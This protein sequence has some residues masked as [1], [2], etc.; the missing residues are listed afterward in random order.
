MIRNYDKFP[1]YLKDHGSFCCWNYEEVN[2]RKTKVPYDPITGQRAKSNDKSTFTYFEV[3]ASKMYEGIGIGIF[4]GVCAIDLDHCVAEDGAFAPSVQAIIDLM[5]SYTEY[6]PS[7]E[8]LHILFRVE[9]FKYDSEKYYVMNHKNGIEVYVAGATSKY[10]TITGNEIAVHYEFGDRTE[11]LKQLLDQYMKR[12]VP[13]VKTTAGNAINTGNN[14]PDNCELLNK[15]MNSRNGAEFQN[16]WNGNWQGKY[17]SQSEADMALCSSLAF[18][19]G[20]D[21]GRIDQLFRQSGLMRE[22]WNRQQ[23]GSTY[24]AIT[25]QKAIQM[26]TDV[27]SP[28]AIMQEVRYETKRTE[29]HEGM[30][31]CNETIHTDEEKNPVQMQ[32]SEK[33][34]GDSEVVVQSEQ[35]TRNPNDLQTISM[36]QLYDNIYQNR[37]PLIEGFLYSGTYLFAG[38]PKVGKSF[39]MAQIAYHVSTGKQLW[40]YEVHKSKVLYLALEDDYQR[41]Q[42]RLFRMF[43]VEGTDDL[44]LAVSSKMVGEGLIDQLERFLKA[45]P[46]TRLIIIDTLQK[47]RE[48][49]V[50]S[51]SYSSD[52]EVIGALKTFADQKGVCVLLVHHTRKTPAGDQ[53]DMISG[54]T[55]LLGCADGAFLMRKQKRT[56]SSATL[57]VVGRD[58]AEQTLYLTKNTD[59]LTWM[60]DHAETEVWKEPSDPIID[61]VVQF[62]HPELPEW[63]GTATELAEKLSLNCAANAL[64]RRLNVKAGK[65]LS[66]HNIIYR[67]VHSRTGSV[68]ELKLEIPEQAQDAE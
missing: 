64:S 44:F 15:A 19:T 59:N 55:G 35:N 13:E 3:A 47:I 7:G 40:E 1:Q 2:G 20:A 26:T 25:I 38:S 66:E 63:T 4:D 18:W 62:I 51:Y 23:A 12:P 57:D 43:G 33:S 31:V 52:Y 32:E 54:T 45:E 16:L 53:F 42:S 36:N 17:Q 29:S 21:V 30:A 58:Q 48:V 5:Q 67:N 22:K 11:E 27:Y 9:G 61:A 34:N 56:D 39:L 24:G 14:L 49:T 46:E 68:I 37:P 50:D 65:L 6:S 41:L 28:K 8:G 10:V 60:L